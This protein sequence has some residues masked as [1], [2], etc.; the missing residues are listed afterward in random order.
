M[1][2]SNFVGS[3]APVNFAASVAS[4]NVRWAG[5]PVLVEAVEFRAIADGVWDIVAACSDGSR[6]KLRVKK[7]VLT[8]TQLERARLQ[9]RILQDAATN[10]TPLLFAVVGNNSVKQWFCDFTDDFVELQPAKT[11]TAPF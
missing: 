1:A 7:N 9:A 8:E 4:P 11:I 3:T 5:T 10:R 6:R 2:T